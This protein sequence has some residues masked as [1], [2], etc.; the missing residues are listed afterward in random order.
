M[1]RLN[2]VCAFVKNRSLWLPGVLALALLPAA[3]PAQENGKRIA[4]IIGN[5]NY[6]A[7]PLKNAVNDARLMDQAL[8]AAGFRTILR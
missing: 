6:S 4:L 2:S 5:N 7:S 1:L 8:R 3:A